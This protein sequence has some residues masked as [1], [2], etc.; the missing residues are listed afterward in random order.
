MRRLET[1]KLALALV[2]LIASAIREFEVQAAPEVHEAH[3][4]PLFTISKS[5]NK[6]RVQY[7]IRV[8]D[9]C[10]PAGDAPVFAY[11]LML[12]QGP[13][14]T[15]PLLP[16]EVPA[17]GAANQAVLSRG[18]KSAQVRLTLKVVPS[19]PILID[20]FRTAKGCTALSTASINGAPAHLYDVYAKLGWLW[21]VDYLLLQGWS[22]DGSHVITE[23]V[24]R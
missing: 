13:G 4:L 19:R 6:N 15:E 7:A 21:G 2:V 9:D 24:Q 5:E 18:P 14:R 11:W 20:T 10:V 3:E 1:G 23:K 22:A 16:R 17:Y 12:E 8:N